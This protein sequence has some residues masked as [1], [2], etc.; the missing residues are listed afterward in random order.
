MTPTRPVT[1]SPGV[2]LAAPVPLGGSG[3]L[4]PEKPVHGFGEPAEA[5]DHGSGPGCEHVRR[6]ADGY[7]RCR[8]TPVTHIA[9]DDF[10]CG[11]PPLVT[12]LCGDCAEEWIAHLAE[13]G[14]RTEC[15][16][17]EMPGRWTVVPL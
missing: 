1:P 17:C 2:L 7:L 15:A 16:W 13:H 11:C 6:L 3:V 10:T 14:D 5:P 4:A 12:V 8:R 9:T